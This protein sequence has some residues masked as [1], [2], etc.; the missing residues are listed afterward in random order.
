[1]AREYTL[2]K[3]R[4]IGI[5]IPESDEIE[6]FNSGAER[7]FYNLNQAREYIMN[8]TSPKSFLTHTF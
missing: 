2:E 1:M 3:T 6:L 7:I 8:N 4:N 5:K